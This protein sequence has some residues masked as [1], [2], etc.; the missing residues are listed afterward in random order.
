MLH[1]EKHQPGSIHRNILLGY[2][3]T[4]KMSHQGPLFQ[5]YFFYTLW[6]PYYSTEEENANKEGNR[7]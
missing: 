1:I 7:N 4:V 3:F 5:F 6:E 2:F